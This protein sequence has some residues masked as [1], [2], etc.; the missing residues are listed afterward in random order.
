ML[1]SLCATA[2]VANVR[3]VLKADAFC[4]EA[5]RLAEDRTSAIAVF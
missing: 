5:Y 2:D 1:L 4:E 3:D